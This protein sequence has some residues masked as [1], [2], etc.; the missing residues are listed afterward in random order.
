[1]RI[2]TGTTLYFLIDKLQNLG[3]QVGQQLNLR[4]SEPLTHKDFP[5]MALQVL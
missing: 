5:T 4:G 3:I 2:Y 1:M